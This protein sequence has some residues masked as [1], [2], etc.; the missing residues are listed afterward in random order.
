MKT[1]KDFVKEEKEDP[2]LTFRKKVDA[3][4]L[5]PSR[6]GSKGDGGGAGDGGSGGGGSGGSGG[7]S[8]GGGGSLEEGNPL[9]RLATLDKHSVL[10][11]A[12]RKNLTPDENKSRMDTLRKEWRKRGYGFRNTRGKWDEGGGVGSE[13]SLHVYAKGSSK[14]D[15]AELRKHAR[16][17]SKE[18]GQDAFI[19]RTPKGKGTAIW[20]GAARKG[21]K[22]EYGPTRYNVDN[23]YGETEFKIRKPEGMRP[24]I[25]FKPKED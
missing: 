7:G 1:F 21:Q 2:M 17:L 6:S 20:T 10:M 5:V 19:H 18:F 11:S 24:K 15:A 25:A 12:E 13:N 23:P 8:G 22:D 4:R 3:K 9:A 14:K 16:T